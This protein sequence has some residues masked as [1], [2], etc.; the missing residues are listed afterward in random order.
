MS[1]LSAEQ[2]ATFPAGSGRNNFLSLQNDGDNAVV[3][4][5]YNTLEEIPIHLVHEVKDADGNPKTVGCLKY[6]NS[7]PNSV[8]PLCAA[9]FLNKKLMYF[10]VRNEQT[11]DMQIWQRSEAYFEKSMKPYFL[12]YTADG[13]PLCSIPFKIVRNGAKGDTKTTYS[14]I[15]KPADNTVLDEFPEEIVVE[16]SG[17]VKDLNFQELQDYVATGVLPSKNNNNEE[18]VVTPR[19]AAPVQQAAPVRQAAPVQRTAAPTRGATPANNNRRTIN[20]GY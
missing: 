10:N 11:G 15:A 16:E 3:R 9:G 17:I 5:A 4:F 7:Q 12:E 18:A 19:G 13:T 2:A 14:L 6:D 1:R 20:G 8:C